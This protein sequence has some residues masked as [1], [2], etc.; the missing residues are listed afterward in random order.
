MQNL[1]TALI[2]TLF[3]ATFAAAQSNLP[4]RHMTV[5]ADTDFAGNDLQQLFDT[6]EPSCQRA[7]IAL[8]ACIG[9]TYNTKSNACF[10]KSSVREHIPFEGAKSVEMRSFES[11]QI[12]RAETRSDELGFLQ[13][14]DLSN[15]K[16][17]AEKLPAKHPSAQW[18]ADAMREAAY[19][20]EAA[21]DLLS[22]WRWMGA[23]TARTDAAEDWAEYARMLDLYEPAKQSDKRRYTNDAFM[24]AI[25]AH[26]RAESAGTR[27]AALLTMAKTLEQ[28]GRGSDMIPAL[29]LAQSLSNAPE[30]TDLLANARAKYGF[31]IINTEVDNKTASPRI[32]AEFNEELSKSEAD[33]ARYLALPDPRFAVQAEGRK[34]CVSGVEFGARY[35]IT[36][37]A[38]L[39]ADSGE[40]LI[41]DTKQNFYVRDRSPSASFP[42]RGYVLPLGGE[43]S[44]PVETVNAT[45]LDLTLRRVSDRNLLRAMQDGLFAQPL[46][47]YQ[48]EQ[49]GGEIGEEIW[50]GTGLTDGALNQDVTTRLPIGEAIIGQPAGIY[51]LSAAVKDETDR[52]GS[53]AQQWFVL[54]D[55]GLST[56]SGNDGLNIFTKSL[57]T[58]KPMSGAKV[59][60]VSRANRVLAE[61][62]TD[63]T[64]AAHFPS[65]LIAGKSGAAPAMVL[66]HSGEEDMAFLSLTDPAFDLSDR[67]VSGRNAPKALDLFLTTD[68]GAY[69]AGETVFATTLVRDTKAKALEGLPIT[70]VLLR[71]D[72]VEYSRQLSTDGQAGGH[73]FSMPIATTAPRGSWTLEMRS[74]ADGDALTSTTFLVEDFLPERIDFDIGIAATE[75]SFAQPTEATIEARYLFGAPAADLSVEGRIR[76]SANRTIK[77]YPG[78]RFGPHNAGFRSVSDTL[79]SVKTDAAGMANL[80]LNL[81]EAEAA[82]LPLEASISVQISEGSGRPVE[83]NATRP[84]HSATP[85]I[86]LKPLFDGVVSEGTEAGYDIVV[87][88]SDRSLMT[89]NARWTL[90]RLNRRYQWYEQNG[91]WNWEPIITRSKVATGQVAL[92]GGK[93]SV[94]APVEWGG[95]ELV[96]E[97]EGDTY[98]AASEEFDAGWYGD[99]GAVSTPDTLE[100][101]LNAESYTIGNEAQLRVL[102]RSAGTAMVQVMSD[103]LISTEMVELA[104]GENLIPLQVTEAW[105]A[106]AYVTVTHISPMN[107]GESFLPTRAIGL[108]YASVDPAD[109]ALSVEL[110][111]LE[112]T[113]PRQPLNVSI[114]A[115]NIKAGETAYMTLAAVDAGILNLTGFEPPA[116][117]E[118]YFGK[119]K[120][121]VELRDIY[122]RLIDASKG[123]LGRLR[124]GGDAG[125]SAG[126]EGPPP[127]DELVTFFQGPVTIGAD[128]TADVT[129]DVPEF[130]GTLRLMAV[131]WSPTGVGAASKDVIIRDPVVLSASLPNHLSP[132]DSSQLRLE[133]THADGPTGEVSLELASN[134][135]RF[136]KTNLPESFTL[137]EGERVAF[138]VPMTA[139]DEGD[140]EITITLTTPPGDTLAKS[141]TLPVRRL[142]PEVSTTRRLT[143]GAGQSL[144]LDANLTEAYRGQSARALVS[145]GPIAKFDVASLLSELDRYPYGC[146]EQLT[147]AAMPLLYFSSV[148]EGLGLTSRGNVSERV[149]KAVARILTR[150]SS[151]GSFGMWYPS[152]GDLWLDAYVTDFL[153]RARAEGIDVPDLAFKN[154]LGN[155]TN[156]VNSY[157]DFDEGG[158]GLAYALYVLAREGQTSVS[159][160]RYYADVKAAA[161]DTPI[162]KAQLG[163]A[164]AY[165]GDQLRADAMF[166]SA[167]GELAKTAGDQKYT[168][169]DDYGTHRRDTA[170]V[171]ALG[172]EAGSKAVNLAALA[173]EIAGGANRRS[174]QEMVWTLLAVDKL[175]GTAPSMAL[176]GAELDLPVLHMN[177]VQLTAGQTLTNTGNEETDITLT[178]FGVPS[179]APEAGGY[180][181]AIERT[182]FTLDGTPFTDLNVKA[183]DRL[184]THLKVI[185]FEKAAARLM[186]NDPLPAGFEIDNP[187]LLQSGDIGAL[188][189]MKPS[190]AESTEFR[191]ERFLA[192]V[193]A[194]EGQ[195]VELAYIVRAVT[196]GRY[197]HAPA[198]VEDMYRPIYRANTGAGEVTVSAD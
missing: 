195:Y 171:I 84:V 153:S 96:I 73:V 93:G 13:R 184:V 41:K 104:E 108:A 176:N 170:A 194:S 103:S 45:E 141:L 54:S 160:L 113:K 17:Y 197:H 140:H 161:F 38:G 182:Y 97:L 129:F 85:L 117:K 191:S 66:A 122:G 187:N 27:S 126:L 6:D 25:N 86:G 190:H 164:L 156:R 9:Y 158:G 172:Q 165:H 79:P 133:I 60:L 193:N 15:A 169:R 55:I 151:S 173:N 98:V 78:F 128:G 111:S 65:E 70:A 77:A 83:R 125:A 137:G 24:A 57:Q 159:D 157:P 63:A 64:G 74:E 12:A 11:A 180:G 175:L 90:N 134:G 4:D 5:F 100:L 112:Q 2:I 53:V 166:T 50:S 14:Y 110:L 23:A 121:G 35:N 168:W 88:A 102:P 71:P 174:T 91:N 62:V 95:Y 177:D 150:Q 131:V 75:L 59:Q 105:G 146:T 76:L 192:A 32:C 81:P 47:R 189:W 20:R 178:T 40:G 143:L 80:P 7:C 142:D 130:N 92:D 48:E 109:K 18:S 10:P 132:D 181:Y 39:P 155:L 33:F 44:L 138:L 1:I 123:N 114:K 147:S 58:A 186:I 145:A 101:S 31:R 127:T 30:I 51:V 67:G 29:K 52:Y 3:S 148:T 19:D 162:G 26:L 124:S 135:A 21:G 8:K 16:N 106:G 154:A 149:E 36:F 99:A 46:Y 120:L 89:G 69:R 61:A 118:H 183:G 82:G 37:R 139:T 152:S 28:I 188:G 56:A 22:A 196:P 167:V 49:L 136:D 87:L 198:T 107:T 163:A 185:P 72:G 144:A 179:V 68:R 42:G 34:L 43:A 94:T 119:R 115:G 116:P